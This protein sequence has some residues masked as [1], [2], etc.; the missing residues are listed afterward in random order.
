[1]PETVRRQLLILKRTARAALGVL[2][3]TM[4]SS[5]AAEADGPQS[6]FSPLQEPPSPPP[7]KG[8]QLLRKERP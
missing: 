7:G 8:G 5:G 4:A 2:I 1:M 6:L 3:L